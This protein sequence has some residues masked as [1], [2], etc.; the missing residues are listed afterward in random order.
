MPHTATILTVDDNDALRYS[1]TR[2]LRGE[3]YKVL[4]ARTGAEALALADQSPDLITLDLNLP[5]F[6][7]F[8]VCRRLR[9]NPQTAH[10]PILH[11]SATFVEPQHRVRGLDGGADAFLAEPIS[12]DE[13]LA[14]VGALL[15]M[16][17]AER[18]ARLQ[19]AEA[20]RARQELR[21]AHDELEM[22]VQ[23]RTAELARKSEEIR[24]LTGRLLKSQDDERRRL[25]RELHDSTGQM[26]AAM[27]INLDSI[28]S[29]MQG[30]NTAVDKL[31]AETTGYTVEISRQLRTMSYL[32]HPPLLD[33]TGLQ[34]A[35][36][37]YAEGFAQR[38]GIQVDLKIS[39]EFRRLPDDL[40][41]AIFRVVQ[42]SLTNIHRHSGSPTAT[43]ELTNSP[44]N[45]QLQ[46]IDAGKGMP[47][48]AS[49][50]KFVPG[51]GI[52]G[53]QERMR[54]FGGTFEILSKG[55]GTTVVAT[56]P[57]ERTLRE[58]V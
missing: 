11:I 55:K 14:T 52:M 49:R 26:L 56:V 33:E 28:G 23:E 8:E 30:K 20:E 6:D 34:S 17:Q 24:E 13:L 45:I 18:E 44:E 4:E 7:G 32:L 15:R 46:I 58:A 39:P 43:I 29:E 48:R 5:D 57:T 21:A 2:T 37:W 27:K 54:Q 25:A 47:D 36:R 35:L 31:V 1:L 51:V 38:S 19:A 3:G 16:K 53:M 22:R 41:I 10:I 42:E 12:G 40:E 50:G 9:A